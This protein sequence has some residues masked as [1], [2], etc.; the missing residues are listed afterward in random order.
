MRNSFAEGFLDRADIDHFHIEALRVLESTRI[1][2]TDFVDRYGQTAIDRDL[3]TVARDKKHHKESEGAED[4]KESKKISDIFEAV[5]VEQGEL[6]EW[7]GGNAFTMKTSEYDDFENGVDMVIEFREDDPAETSHLGLATD[8]TFRTD[9]TSKFNHIK[10]LIDKGRMAT[11]KYFDGDEHQFPEVIVGAD[12]KTIL[13]LAELRAGRKNNKVLGEHRIQIMVL[14]QMKDQLET[15]AMYAESIGKVDIA[16]VYRERLEL[17]SGILATKSD[18]FKKVA[19]E[20]DD[21]P[22]HFN[23]M[24]ASARIRA[25]LQQGI[26]A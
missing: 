4:K 5:V 21:D 16:R 24:T 15:F 23:I 19:H 11:V 7:F 20:L 18:L 9:S 8:V 2:E 13:E 10:G 1:K 25:S 14:L 3:A 26:A 12:A 6:S 17:V 22:V